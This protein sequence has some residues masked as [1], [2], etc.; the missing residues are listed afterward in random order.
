MMVTS[1][2]WIGHKFVSSNEQYIQIGLTNSRRLDPRISYE[3][4]TELPNETLKGQLTE[5][6][7]GGLLVTSDLLVRH[8]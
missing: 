6:T 1:L 7:L 4:L 2:E 5:E 3:V 8:R